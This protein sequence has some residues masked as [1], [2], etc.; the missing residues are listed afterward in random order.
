MSFVALLLI[1]VG[2]SA[3]AFAVAG[4]KGLTMRRAKAIQWSTGVT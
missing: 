4:G 1:A 2:E 3:D